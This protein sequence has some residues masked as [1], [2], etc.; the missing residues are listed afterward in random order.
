[1]KKAY[2]LRM[3]IQILFD[4]AEM[5]GH[6]L[7]DVID[8]TPAS[9]YG[10]AN[11]IQIPNTPQIKSLAIT[12]LG[13]HIFFGPSR[14][15]KHSPKVAKNANFRNPIIIGY[16]LVSEINNCVSKTRNAAIAAIYIN[17]TKSDI[18]NFIQ[19][20]NIYN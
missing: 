14:F 6:R 15:L 11:V 3:L 7:A 18:L 1:M 9:A 4:N 20:S 12:L 10:K 19:T 16:I 8:L 13:S 17:A 2:P 5:L